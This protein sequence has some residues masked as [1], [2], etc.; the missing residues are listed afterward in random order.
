[1]RQYLVL[2]FALAVVQANI[3]DDI[4]D[5]NHMNTEEL[6]EDPNGRHMID[7]HEMFEGDI[8]LTD[9]NKIAIE[10]GRSLNTPLFD[11][12]RSGKWPNGVVPYT[13]RSGFRYRNEVLRAIAVFEAQTCLKFVA[14]TNQRNYIQ[15][16]NG[17]GCYA[18]IGR[19][20]IVPQPVSI[21]SGCQSTG[22]IIH[23][24]MHTIGFWHEQ[25][26]LDR[27]NYIRIN[28]NNVP[29]NY[30]RQ[31]AK[32]SASQASTLGEPYDK[33]SVMHY[34]RYAFAINRRIPVI[35]SRSNP[36]ED[37]GQRNGFSRIDL[38][39]VRKHYECTNNPVTVPPTNP[40]TRPPTR[41]PTQPPTA[42]P[43]CTDKWIWCC[44]LNDYC[45]KSKRVRDN[46]KKTCNT[47]N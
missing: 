47:C 20:S 4:F 42:P 37:L 41:P 46:C 1:M 44:R 28:L 10:A 25:S 22:I 5:T 17:Q 7:Q 39:Q 13:F 34:G 3:M 18:Y 43:G 31:F 19:T 27:D 2:I 6:A 30:H 36:N 33:Q 21:G 14:R 12:N 11:A 26:R 9:E 16:I 35:T 38:N 40:P 29:S 15:F 8:L 32:Y 23:E 24:L 45:P